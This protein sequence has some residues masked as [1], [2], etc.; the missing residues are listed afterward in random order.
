MRLAVLI[1]VFNAGLNLQRTLASLAPDPFPFDIV[2]VDDG[3]WQPVELPDAIGA[4][5]VVLLRH[6][7]NRGIAHALNTGMEYIVARGYEYLAR[8][9]AGDIN[10]PRR[11]ATQAAHLDRYQRVALVGAWTRHVDEQLRPLFTTRYPATWDTIRRRLHYRTAF[12]HPACMIRT[13]VLPI[14]GD[15]NESFIL[16]ED[17]ELFWRLAQRFPCENIPEVLVTRLESRDS[18][19]YRKRGAAARTRLRLQWQHFAW[20]RLDCWLGLARSL[21]LL[22]LPARVVFT[23]KKAVGTI[24]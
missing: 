19:I 23:L 6:D 10:E 20:G 1:P 8:L 22:A 13:R 24:G 15:Y 18:L 16:G 5:S 3:T 4:H 17:Y 9:D 14:A 11:L 12:S 2:V 7:R 21:T